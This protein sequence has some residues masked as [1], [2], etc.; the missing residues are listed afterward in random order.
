MFIVS[1][2]EIPGLNAH[3]VEIILDK[4]GTSMKDLEPSSVPPIAY[5]LLLLAG[6]SHAARLVYYFD[7]Y[8]AEIYDEENIE[9]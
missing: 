5:Q 7:K 1:F 8:F 3:E 4:A 2:S 6:S 9:G